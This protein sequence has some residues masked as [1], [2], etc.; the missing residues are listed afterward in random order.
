MTH[1]HNFDPSNVTINHKT[2]RKTLSQNYFTLFFSPTMVVFSLITIL[3]L[4]RGAKLDKNH[5]AV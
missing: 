3:I 5:I 1:F 2:K 4:L